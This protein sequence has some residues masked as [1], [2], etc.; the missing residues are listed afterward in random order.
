ML[1]PLLPDPLPQRAC[2]YRNNATVR[3]PA[4]PLDQPGHRWAADPRKTGLALRLRHRIAPRAA[5]RIMRVRQGVYAKISSSRFVS[6]LRQAFLSR[7]LSTST[8]SS[9]RSIL[10]DF[11][12][13]RGAPHIGLGYTFSLNRRCIVVRRAR[14]PKVPR[15]TFICPHFPLRFR[16]HALSGGG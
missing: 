7:I 4:H 2:P 10:Q 6:F 3:S 1:P 5:G 14:A 13:R 9:L 16:E 15:P 8:S 11:N 12:H